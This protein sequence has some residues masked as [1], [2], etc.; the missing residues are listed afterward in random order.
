MVETIAG[1]SFQRVL[2][3]MQVSGVDLEELDRGT[4]M[5]FY[6]TMVNGLPISTMKE[7]L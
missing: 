3:L 2:G 6:V 4:V 7:V 5:K 1:G